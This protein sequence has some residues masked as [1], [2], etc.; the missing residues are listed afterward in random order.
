MKHLE[1]ILSKFYSTT[2]TI[3]KK[4]F[5]YIVK[6]VSIHARVRKMSYARAN[7]FLIPCRITE[8]PHLSLIFRFSSITFKL[9][10]RFTNNLA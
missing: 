4:R 10:N 5:I 1:T 8:W 7:L 6:I 9:M 2:C 3:I